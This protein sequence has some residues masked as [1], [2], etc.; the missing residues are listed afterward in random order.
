MEIVFFYASLVLILSVITAISAW[1][2][3]KH[4]TT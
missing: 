4:T 3:Q 2:E 1:N